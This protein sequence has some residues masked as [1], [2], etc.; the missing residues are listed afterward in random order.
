LHAV[1]FSAHPPNRSH[2][3]GHAKIESLSALFESLLLLATCG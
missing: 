1:R 3:Y 2:L